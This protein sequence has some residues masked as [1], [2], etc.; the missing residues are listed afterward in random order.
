[1]LADDGNVGFI[2]RAVRDTPGGTT[3]TYADMYPDVPRSHWNRRLTDLAASGSLQYVDDG[4]RRR[5]Y[6]L[7]HDFG[8]NYADE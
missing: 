5:Y 8:G 4:T 1:M 3:N 2:A 7:T 6:L